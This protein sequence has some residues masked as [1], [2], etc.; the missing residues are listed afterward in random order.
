MKSILVSLMSLVLFG[1]SSFSSKDESMKTVAQVDLKKFMGDWYVLAGRF[2]PLEKEVHNAVEVYTW[3]EKEERIDIGFTYNKG[4]FDGKVK[5]IPQKGWIHNQKTKA[6]W[7]V[8]PLW[9]LKFDYLIVGLAEDYSWT[10]IGVP[11]Q[12]YLWIMARSPEN[13]EA[14]VQKAVSAL[15]AVGYKSDQLVLVPH[16][17]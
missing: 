14:T 9:P 5:S 7:K 16:K 3:N 1:C 17:K 6:H 10:A 15:Q 2:T 13:P 11:D 4:S 12:S 8:S